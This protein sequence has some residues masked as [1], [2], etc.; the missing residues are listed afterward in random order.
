VFYG[1]AVNIGVAVPADDM[2][3]EARS[4]W[5]VGRLHLH[6]QQV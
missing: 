2:G 4:P 6:Y 5:L 1:E 3:G